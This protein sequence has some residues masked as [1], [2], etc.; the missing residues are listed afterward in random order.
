LYIVP[1]VMIIP[2]IG[3][4]VW[5]ITSRQTEPDL[6]NHIQRGITNKHHSRFGEGT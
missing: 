1:F 4:Q 6:H 5:L 3:L 2:N